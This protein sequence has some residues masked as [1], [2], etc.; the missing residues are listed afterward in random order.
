MSDLGA[1][2]SSGSTG[3][4][5]LVGGGSSL[6]Q[7]STSFQSS[8]DSAK[9]AASGAGGTS[10]AGAAAGAS[11]F[12]GAGST[13][14]S[15]AQP[16]ST[17]AAAPAG[18]TVPTAGAGAT[19]VTGTPA[20]A[21]P[22]TTGSAPAA[23][24]TAGGTPQAASSRPAATT[25]GTGTSSVPAGT[26]TTGT[27]ATGG[28][29]TTTATT[30]SSASASAASGTSS[31]SALS[32]AS[33][34]VTAASLA[35][36]SGLEALGDLRDTSGSGQDAA[37]RDAARAVQR[38]EANR[39]A[40]E[41]G[42][43]L[44]AAGSRAVAAF[45]ALPAS[46][47]ASQRTGRIQADP[48]ARSGTGL[49]STQ[50][51]AFQSVALDALRNDRSDRP[52]DAGRAAM[53]RGVSDQLARL[54]AGAASGGSAALT[55]A[56][57]AIGGLGT[58]GTRTGS[59][60]D[61]TDLQAM[62]AAAFGNGSATRT[63]TGTDAQ[64]LADRAAVQAAQAAVANLGKGPAARTAAGTD[65][66][67]LAD[68]AA[69]EAARTAFSRGGN[70]PGGLTAAGGG[71]A[72]D[73]ER[74]EVQAMR[75]AAAHVRDGSASRTAAGTDAQGLTD[76]A[77]V[78]AARTAF[79]RGGDRAAE[80]KPAAAGQPGGADG[81]A[82]QSARAAIANLAAKDSA[83][84]AT[85][86]DAQGLAARD[87]DKVAGDKAA[88]SQAG[89]ITAAALASAAL[90]GKAATAPD[91]G[92]AGGTAA[93]AAAS[94]VDPSSGIRSV[95][96][97]DGKDYV[98]V[99]V[100]PSGQSGAGVQSSSSISDAGSTANGTAGVSN[101]KTTTAGNQEVW[102]P[103]NT[104]LGQALLEPANPEGMQFSLHLPNWAKNL[105]SAVTQTVEGGADAVNKYLN[106]TIEA[107]K[108][109][110]AGLQKVGDAFLGTLKASA[111]AADGLASEAYGY[112]ADKPEMGEY[113]KQLLNEAKTDASKA[114]DEALLGAVM[115]T[116]HAPP[117]QAKNIIGKFA[118]VRDMVAINGSDQVRKKEAG[119][120]LNPLIDSVETKSKIIEQ[121]LYNIRTQGDFN[122]D[123]RTEAAYDHSMQ[124]SNSS[125]D[126][127]GAK[128]D[129]G[130]DASGSQRTLGGYGL[131]VEQVRVGGVFKVGNNGNTGGIVFKIYDQT[132]Y[133]TQPGAWTGD[134]SAAGSRDLTLSWKVGDPNS[135]K[136]LTHSSS[137]GVMAETT[138]DAKDLSGVGKAGSEFG[139]KIWN[140]VTDGL[141]GISN[142]LSSVAGAG[143]AGIVQ[144]VEGELARVSGEIAADMDALTAVADAAGD[145]G[146]SGSGSAARIEQAVNRAM[147]SSETE[148]V[149]RSGGSSTSSGSAGYESARSGDNQSAG[150]S[151]SG[152]NG[153]GAGGV[154]G[155][156]ASG[157]GSHLERPSGSGSQGTGASGVDGG[158]VSEGSPWQY[159]GTSSKVEFGLMGS[160]YAKVD[161]TNESA[162]KIFGLVL[163]PEAL[164]AG[165]GWIAP[166][167]VTA[168]IPGAGSVIAK[169]P[170]ASQLGADILVL[171]ADL[172]TNQ[173][174]GK[175]EI[176]VSTS[177]WFDWLYR[178]NGSYDS[179]RFGTFSGGAGTRVQAGF[180]YEH[181]FTSTM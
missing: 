56:R 5:G 112:L 76:K 118:L 102:V 180:L 66:Q 17:P 77:A 95:V 113:G 130:I 149:G 87:A 42:A 123:D 39:K 138:L 121:N 143:Q 88:A 174:F 34:P 70:R 167:V 115:V 21:T 72:A 84:I 2:L 23:Q 105:V 166:Y 168:L 44:Q 100:G 110:I 62:R 49:S 173:F 120:R 122:T 101:A 51:A 67:G 47:S 10:P 32:A 142:R 59:D 172:I 41:D 43:G 179:Q 114:G 148:S 144:S 74:N 94:D 99:S 8:I 73:A 136:K 147:L 3:G 54:P 48:A 75:A 152:S 163:A 68:K 83:K 104:V 178:W 92:K 22:A 141:K 82:V 98:A 24:A 30:G 117:D 171:G 137:L 38:D 50:M 20:A 25:G 107:A 165:A 69:V 4:S 90:N 108:N 125:K 146:R 97:K 80:G 7:L 131:N 52:D 27:A 96:G 12:G 103:K 64:G 1:P 156:N 78:E 9:Q 19:P 55:A 13:P 164:G 37:R 89:G 33:S 79:A 15:A 65:A 71:T 6:G 93:T 154:D 135:G 132:G 140:G 58:T 16:A 159:S 106:G 128:I 155:G 127:I 145:L 175:H 129:F 170:S 14:V 116:M 91:S 161:L 81:A 86:T 57:S 85:G 151:G 53:M 126:F 139:N 31:A 158:N 26:G 124:A 157:G 36:S 134:V 46:V 109:D 111:K 35:R 28:A 169:L 40:A 162:G 18:S 177:T 11:M 119:D 63:A 133:A 61:R 176:G 160:L 181:P 29:A 153:A 150:P 45:T 60:V